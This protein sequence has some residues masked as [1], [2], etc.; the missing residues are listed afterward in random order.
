M[1]DVP[2]SDLI[3][4]NHVLKRSI[5]DERAVQHSSTRDLSGAR[6][7]LSDGFAVNSRNVCNHER[8]LQSAFAEHEDLPL[9]TA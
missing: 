8:N 7:D 5:S 9:V 4:L 6:G 2:R 1:G 3:I